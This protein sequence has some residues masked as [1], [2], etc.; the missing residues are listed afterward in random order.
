MGINC[1]QASSYLFRRTPNFLK[2]LVEDLFP[3]DMLYSTL[4]PFQPWPSF[5]GTELTWDRIHVNMPN[6]MGDWEQM[7]SEDCLINVC[8]P[9]IRQLDW[10]STRSVFGKFRRRWKTR[11]L[12]LDQLRHIEEAKAQIAMIYKGLMKVPEYVKAEFMKYQ[13]AAGSNYIYSCGTGLTSVAVT[14]GMFPTGGGLASLNMGSDANLPTSKLSMNYLQQYVPQL[15]YNGYFDGQ[16]TPTGKLQIITDMQSAIELCNQNPALA[17]MYQGADFEKGGQYFKYGAMMGCG[18]FLFDIATYP[19]RFYRS[20]P[21]VLTRVMPFQNEAATVGST[22]VL[23]PQWLNAPYQLSHVP[24]RMAR[25]VYRGEIPEL[26][27]ETKFGRRDLWGKWNW[28]NDAVLMSFD[29]N[30]GTTCTLDNVARNWGYFWADYEAGVQ[31]TRPELEL[32]ILHQRE[33]TAVADVPRAAGLAT[34]PTLVAQSL[35]PYNA[36]CNPNP[37]EET[38]YGNAGISDF[39]GVTPED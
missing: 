18:N 38:Y 19:A 12:C 30:S 31:N 26:G 21:G 4:Y 25:D 5:H 1:G 23:D 29:P 15:Q 22:P 24:H 35:L 37:G 14:S 34:T 8:N 3:R 32:M 11:V 16:F 9:E 17:G 20:T 28:C 36:Y 27:G 6:D 7:R 13:C 33:T 10:G 39:G 2:D